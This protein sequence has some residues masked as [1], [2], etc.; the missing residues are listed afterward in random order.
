M[1]LWQLPGRDPTRPSLPAGGIEEL[2][3]HAARSLVTNHFDLLT[4][5]A[6][7]QC[8]PAWERIWELNIVKT[9]RTSAT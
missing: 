4:A 7:L 9:M 1:V 8:L 6:S 2:R 5:T 3:W